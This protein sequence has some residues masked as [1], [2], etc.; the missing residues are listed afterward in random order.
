DED[1]R[2]NIGLVVPLLNIY[3]YVLGPMALALPHWIAVGATV[4]AV[5]LFTARAG[6]HDLARRIEMREIVTAAE[7][8]ILTGLVLPLLP[9]TPVTSLTTITPHQVWLA[10]IVVS[11]ISYAS[12]L[13]QRFLPGAADGLWMAALGG[14]YSS[15]ATTVVLAR[16][17]K[18]E[19]EG[20][21]QA[22][23]GITLATA[24][25]YAR[26]L[27]IVGIFNLDLARRLA[28][29]LCGLALAA[30]AI[31]IVQYRFHQQATKPA[32]T[33][34]ASRNPLELGTA[35]V[36]ASLFVLTSLLSTWVTGQFG[37]EGIYWLAAAIGFA[38]ID[39]F[40][41][42]LAQGGAS[43][44][45]EAALAASILIAASSNNLLKA[46]YAAIFGGGRATTGSAAALVLLAAGGL[47]LALLA[48][49]F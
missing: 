4:A 46:A 27:V 19:P 10:L 32:D 43:G 23:A 36:F 35:A 28:P 47:A 26:V 37:T 17:A 16:K 9:N 2:P 7:F 33:L 8:L 6:L 13:S 31:S 18:A 12:Y 48:P 22:Q 20:S 3:A 41:L 14:L 21:R 5:L 40:V 34:E 1:G 29:A 44:V 49:S 30:L 39:P 45:P 15:T 11:S 25:M 24:I 38:D 42:N